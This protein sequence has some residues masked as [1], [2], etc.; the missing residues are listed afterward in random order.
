MEVKR[1]PVGSKVG[2]EREMWFL[3]VRLET[4]PKREGGCLPE[5][6][7]GGSHASLC[8]VFVAGVCLVAGGTRWVVPHLPFPPR[9]GCGINDRLL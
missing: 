8:K 1:P 9:L 5:G 6:G 2:W 4:L 7:V 3:G